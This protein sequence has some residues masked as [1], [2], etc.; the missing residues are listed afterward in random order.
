VNPTDFV[1]RVRRSGESAIT[2]ADVAAFRYRP[3]AGRA[4]RSQVVE[5]LL[6]QYSHADLPVLRALIREE[7]HAREEH[8]GCGRVLLALATMLSAVG[9]PEDVLLVHA[10]RFAN[11][12]A[13]VAIGRG[14]L[15]MGSREELAAAVRHQLERQPQ[16]STLK[17]VLEDLDE[18]FSDGATHDEALERARNGLETAWASNT[19][20]DEAE[21]EDDDDDDDDEG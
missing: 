9:A 20:D 17:R 3:G 21:D 14:L 10:A 8:G 12:D 4:V 13:G 19:L 15:R 2:P 11:M 6:P 7:T 1:A 5:L 16:L 18:A